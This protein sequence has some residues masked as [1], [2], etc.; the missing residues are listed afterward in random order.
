VEADWSK[1]NFDGCPFNDANSII[2]K[3]EHSVLNLTSPE[4]LTRCGSV[5]PTE[6]DIL[7][8][9]GGL[10]DSAHLNRLRAIFRDVVTAQNIA[11]V[12]EFIDRYSFE[13]NALEELNIF[14]ALVDFNVGLL[15]DTIIA[16]DCSTFSF[17]VAFLRSMGTGMQ[18]NSVSTFSGMPYPQQLGVMPYMCDPL[19][20]VK[21]YGFNAWNA[22][23]AFLDYIP[24]YQKS[25]PVVFPP[26]LS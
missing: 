2:S 24:K 8:V 13:S 14:A 17:E 1:A 3:I 10:K 9:A 26:V 6:R 20:G 22:T 25:S 4:V 15:S 5:P 7:Y 18:P 16:C 23:G 19:S 12:G 11:N 21:D